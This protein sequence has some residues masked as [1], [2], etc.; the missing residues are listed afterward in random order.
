M[1]LYR[2]NLLPGTIYADYLFLRAVVPDLSQRNFLVDIA[3][4]RNSD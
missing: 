4:T 1:S 3:P 2:P